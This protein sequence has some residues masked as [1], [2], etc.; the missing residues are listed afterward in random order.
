MIAG[1]FALLVSAPQPASAM[2]LGL[3][4]AA[5]TEALPAGAVH[6]VTRR[7]RKRYY[8]YDWGY[9]DDY[10]RYYY[11]RRYRRYDDTAII[12]YPPYYYP[13]YAPPPYAYYRTYRYERR[14]YPRGYGYP[15]Y[16]PY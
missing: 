2:S 4:D 16:Y 15:A 14:V 3:A 7:W 9:Y 13:L 8:D 12:Y 10:P 6:Q 1:A 5:R 11:P